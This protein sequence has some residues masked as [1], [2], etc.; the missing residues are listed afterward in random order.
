MR[1]YMTHLRYRW[2]KKIGRTRA[3]AARGCANA[4]PAAMPLPTEAREGCRLALWRRR[5]CTPA[6][7][8]GRRRWAGSGVDGRRSCHYKAVG[9]W[10][11][12]QSRL[13][14]NGQWFSTSEGVASI[15][16]KEVSGKKRTRWENAG[17]VKPRCAER[18]RAQ[19]SHSHV[20]SCRFEP[21][22]PLSWYSVTAA[23]R[24]SVVARVQ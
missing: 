11:W 19:P 20:H 21:E 9:V 5:L 13:L 23:L 2:L 7:V 3:S 10:G 14:W 17:L 4:A 18:R 1:E 6:G 22:W 16:L 8:D 15:F 24:P 12:G